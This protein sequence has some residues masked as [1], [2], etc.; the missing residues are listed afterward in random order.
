MD[1]SGSENRPWNSVDRLTCGSG[2][3]S[4]LKTRPRFGC[5]NI[6]KVGS[7]VA[8]RVAFKIVVELYSVFG[9]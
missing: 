6:L 7:E 1:C 5:Y 2:V 8:T 9:F 4:H 3:V